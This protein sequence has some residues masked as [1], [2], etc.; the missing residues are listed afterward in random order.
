MAADP[1]IPILFHEVLPGG[2]ASHGIDPRDIGFGTVSMDSSKWC[3]IRTQNAPQSVVIVDLENPTAAPTRFPVTADS[4]I[5]NP[6]EK[7]LALRAGQM[8]QI[9]HIDM[10]RKIKECKLEQR[11][12]FWKW[13]SSSTIAIVTASAV[14][15]WSMDGPDPPAKVFDRHASLE[16]AQ[17]INYR[18]D[19]TQQ[20]LLLIGILQRDGR[21]AGSMQ[22]F[23][24]EKGVSQIIEGHAGAFASHTPKGAAKPSILFAFAFRS[25]SASKLF[26]LEV[27]AGEGSTFQKQSVDIFYPPDP[28]GAA[29]FPVAMQIDEK[30]GIIFMVTKT[31]YV[32][33]F[34]LVTA[35][36]IYMNRI[37]AET[38]FVT[39]P[40]APTHGLVGI[41]RPGHV[42]SVSVAEAN[43]VQYICN[44]LRNPA[45]AVSLAS[46]AG[47]PGAD[48]IFIN[49]FNALFSQGK[50]AEAA[51]IAADSP[52][53][54]LRTM[55]TIQ[56]FQAL[57][58]PPGQPSP[59]F[60]YFSVL[61]EAGPLNAVESI[62]L[63]KPVLLQGK[64]PLV[65]QWLAAD[66]L[67]CSEELGDLMRGHDLKMA[68]QIYYR[69]EVRPKV[70]G[71]F[72]ET[73]QYDKIVTYCQRVNYSPDWSIL[74]HNILAAN[75]AGAQA[76]AATLLNAPGG[77]MIDVDLVI[78][79]FLSRNMIQDITSLLLDFLKPN[80]PQDAALQ[81]R[82]I[83]I[84]LI[85]APKAA[86]A[87]LNTKMFTHFN[88][89][90]LAPLAENA[91]LYQH[92]LEMYTDIKDI[93][94]VMV[95]TFAISPAWLLEYFTRLDKDEGF[96]CLRALLSA[97]Q[98]NASLVAQLAFRYSNS[99]DPKAT[100]ALFE[101][102]SSFEGLYIFLQ[103]L[104]GGGSTDQDVHNKYIMAATRVGH[105]SEVEKV[106][107]ESSYYDP[108][109]I[110]QFFMESKLADQ[111]PLIIVCDRFDY[112]EDLTRY[113]Y[114]NNMSSYIEIYVQ[115]INPLNT[116]S[117]VGALLDVDCN[118][119]YIQSLV[120][121]VRNQAPIDELVAAVEKRNRLKLLSDWLEARAQEGN[122]D[123][124]LHNALAKIY[125]DDSFKDAAQFLRDNKYY[126]PLVVGAFAESR[127]AQLAF[128]AF[129]RG[130]CDQEI[131]A[132][133]HQH[134]LQKLLAR[135]LLE[136][137]SESLW[138]LALDPSNEDRQKLIDQIVQVAL[139]ESEDPDQVIVAVRAFIA[140]E[141]PN[142][143]IDLLEKLV[144]EHSRFANHKA[145]Q[146][147]LLLTAIRSN[148]SLVMNYVHRLN[149]FDARD[150]ALIAAQKG[151]FEEAFAMFEK[152]KHY[153]GAI[154]ILIENLNTDGTFERALKFAE[155]VKDPS[156]W[157]KLG[158]AQ[159]NAN[160]VSPA[161]EAFLK[162][163]NHEHF[164]EVITQAEAQGHFEQLVRFLEMCRKNLGNSK[165]P[166]VETELIFSY[167][168]LNQLDKLEIFISS[169]NCA[170]IQQVGD[171]A[172]QDGLYPAAKILFTNI[173]NYPR[174]ASC[175][176]KLED[177][178]AAVEAARKAKSTR[179]WKEV[180][181]ACVEA[182]QFKLA[183]VCGLNI[184][185]HGDELE[186][187][188][189]HYEARCYFDEIIALLDTGLSMDNVHV[190]IYT[191][192]AVLLSKYK[193]SRLMEHLRLYHGK[194]HTVKVIRACEQN[195]QWTEVTFLYV[196]S[197]DLESALKT[198][199]AHSADAFDHNTFKEVIAKV[200]NVDE[201][202]K[203][204]RFYLREHP[205]QTVDL[206]RVVKDKVDQA[207]IVAI[208]KEFKLVPLI[209]PYLQSIQEVDL[210]AV[211]EALNTTFIEEEDYL[212]LRAS[213]SA[214]KNFDARALAKA[215]EDHDLLEFRRIAA[216]IYKTNNMW[217]E[218]LAL[219]KRD[220][221]WQDAIQ[222]AA[223]SHDRKLAEDLLHFFVSSGR[224]DCFAA[225][226][227]ACYD[228]IRPDVA[229]ELGWRYKMTDFVMPFLVQ[230]LRD[231]SLKIESLTKAV[232]PPEPDASK[233]TAFNQPATVQPLPQVYASSAG[234][235]MVP[236]M[237][238]PGVYSSSASIPMVVPP[239]VPGG[240]VPGMVPGGIVPGGVVP[241]MIPGGVVPGF[242][243]R[244]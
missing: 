32:H 153:D 175:L 26:V 96:E 195:L 219:S 204:V 156:V 39:A 41:N 109:V 7:I 76:F 188:I 162:A 147:L 228:L 55:Q 30:N 48:E 18:T 42:L 243:P 94:R 178:T 70:I 164:S 122:T 72:A 2:L 244:I 49:Q 201:I 16:G 10:R 187:L 238:A 163:N 131:I 212:A 116:P 120:L 9:F 124:A 240:I 121:S 105:T 166:R 136:R 185:T 66:K 151:L 115:K 33:L 57:P 93:K 17:I 12:D 226:L 112:I 101:E 230:T 67:G 74:L 53:G 205:L 167:A 173:S 126:D 59:L 68:L 209:K 110:K 180:N 222:S 210:A 211:N 233:P 176:V 227:Y 171:R 183:Q 13:I 82:L 19:A 50:F 47:L 85:Q 207:R 114:Q 123:P 77:P 161:I 174:L 111:L 239:V 199:V 150:M 194:L 84:N 106:V 144:L 179:T 45:L 119:K 184:I 23:S 1:N 155:T 237:V 189:R 181:R 71:I 172:F 135:Y 232:T 79:A 203:C 220:N 241:G 83:Q 78:D 148:Q 92:A 107:R 190:G 242:A 100:I 206:L 31:G 140:A 34:D 38:I 158:H 196:H 91:G 69:A 145:L 215:I 137:Q 103:Q 236:G 193:P 182:Q 35:T 198:M 80:R 134:N 168:K 225:C 149:D 218:S 15:H 108:E 231:N 86:E 6:V 224:P 129:K 221:L 36:V 104:V 99:I 58:V 64:K 29:D 154:Q 141:L 117:V 8:L 51:R 60:Q 28:S 177:Y 54:I 20:W 14:Y 5:I 214:F 213:I 43:I 65:E 192:L 25:A 52:R 24:R 87:I 113:L 61:L 152:F 90:V 157:S 186:E 62:E 146:N 11:I 88:P 133:A 128:I 217:Q 81:T 95:N 98:A 143:L 3:C 132:L 46:R 4:A 235:P 169:P 138:A 40:H 102:Y 197:D 63:V 202:Y 229:L 216:H 208:A 73:G 170:Q 200:K 191:S 56:R 139:P 159:L 44:V 130:N 118:E 27:G 165:V 21:I 89:Q 142:Q 75:P 37:S 127:D 97:N 160:Q 125:I 22:L 234:I 223:D